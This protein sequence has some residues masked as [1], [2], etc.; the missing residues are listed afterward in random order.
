[1]HNDFETLL[2]TVI[3]IAKIKQEANNLFPVS[4]IS[5]FSLASAT[6]ALSISAAPPAPRPTGKT[7]SFPAHECRLEIS[8]SAVD[9]SAAAAP[10]CLSS[11]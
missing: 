2:N 8:V 10:P 9:I 1:M 3:L 7:H 11:P 5:V 4:K 6:P